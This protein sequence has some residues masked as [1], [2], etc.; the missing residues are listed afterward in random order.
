MRMNLV[1]P[2]ALWKRV[3]Y[4][5]C[6]VQLF[7]APWTVA[8]QASLSVGFSRQECWSG[9]SFPPPGDL[10]YPG[11]EPVSLTSPEFAGRFFTSSATLQAC[12][13]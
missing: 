7:V 12:P 4:A 8:Q 9:V 11:I 13:G 3:C 6:V 1:C 10:P 2:K 5:V